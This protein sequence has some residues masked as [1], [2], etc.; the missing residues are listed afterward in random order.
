MKREKQLQKCVVSIEY[1]KCEE[2]KEREK[3][4]FT[5]VSLKFFAL[6]GGVINED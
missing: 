2:S 1:N 3:L 5:P 6:D 4:R